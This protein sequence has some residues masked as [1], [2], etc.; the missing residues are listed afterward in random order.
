MDRAKEKPHPKGDQTPDANK[1]PRTPNNPPTGKAG[2]SSANGRE[3]TQNTIRQ[4]A[5]N[6]QGPAPKS[7][8]KNGPPF[9]DPGERHNQGTPHGKKPRTQD[10]TEEDWNLV[11][12]AIQDYFDPRNREYY[13]TTGHNHPVKELLLI[14]PP[15]FTPTMSHDHRT[16]KS[17]QQETQQQTHTKDK[18]HTK[19]QT[20]SERESSKPIGGRTI[21]RSGSQTTNNQAIQPHIVPQIPPEREASL[22]GERDTREHE[23][24]Q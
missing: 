13:L 10:I 3:L 17:R 24:L 4:T 19:P 11:E 12:D 18:P 23:P 20:P 2:P 9:Y 21:P 16:P 6:T 5:H 8:R 22:S 14:T 7:T 15:S 1:N